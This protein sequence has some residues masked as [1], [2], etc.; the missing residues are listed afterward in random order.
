V[1]R[2][3]TIKLTSG[4][5][6]RLDRFVRECSDAAERT[7]ALI[8]LRSAEGWSRPELAAALS[9]SEELVT[10]VRRRWV[11]EGAAGL[12]DRREDNG[13]RKV[14]D[15]YVQALLSIL[16]KSPRDFGF[17]RPTWTQPLLIKCA[18]RATGIIISVSRMSRL[19]KELGVRLGRPKP[20]APRVW[21][22]RAR[23]KRLRLIHRLIESLRSDEACVWEDE[24][25]LDLNPRIGPDWTLPGTQRVV[26]TPGQN[27]KRYLAASLDACTNRLIW[28]E[29]KRK[30]SGLFIAMLGRLLRRYREKR[31]IHVILDNYTIHT[32]RRTQAWLAERGGRIRLHFLPPYCPDDNRIERAVIRELHAN[33]TRNHQHNN[34]EDL[35][36]D[37]A[38][39]L[40][41]RDR[42]AARKLD[43]SRKAI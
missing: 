37:A 25:D 30:D 7:R 12:V 14:T 31:V 20:A 38:A 28:A 1:K 3:W 22:N 19:L 36:A 23:T 41:A 16:R 26:V 21:S 15:A 17:R 5:R 24:L 29:G 40:A 42:G 32:S 39:Y 43:R 18:Q 6:R 10:K 13:E 34:I 27:V 4:Q 2:S 9:C 11:Q 33:V 8:V 35:A